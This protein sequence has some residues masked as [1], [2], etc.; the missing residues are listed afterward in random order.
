MDS[1]RGMDTECAPREWS[2]PG[3]RDYAGLA[4]GC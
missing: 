1:P 4:Q 3:H 2:A